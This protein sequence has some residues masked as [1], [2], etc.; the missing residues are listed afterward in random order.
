M[1]HDDLAAGLVHT[2]SISQGCKGITAIVWAVLQIH[3][4]H[5]SV[6]VGVMVDSS[7]VVIAI[8]ISDQILPVLLKAV[9]DQRNDCFMDRDDTVNAG[10]C[11]GTADHVSFIQMHIGGFNIQQL[12]RAASR[13]NVH[14]DDIHIIDG[15]ESIPESFDLSIC[16]AGMDRSSSLCI[17]KAEMLGDIRFHMF[18]G[19]SIA[20]HSPDDRPHISNRRL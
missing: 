16:K 8:L 20:P 2:S 7:G 4:L 9:T 5:D 18:V 14:E 3:A 11:L 15:A 1:S 17:F 10:F 13:I 12:H 19:Y 6:P